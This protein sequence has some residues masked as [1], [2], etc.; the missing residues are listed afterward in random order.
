MQ[1]GMMAAVYHMDT[2]CTNNGV[3][4]KANHVIIVDP[5]LPQI[6]EATPYMPA[7]Y[8]IKRDWAYWYLCP[9]PTGKNYMFGGNFAYDCDSRSMAVLGNH[10]IHIFDRQ[11]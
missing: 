6:F 11:E 9:D 5:L 7:L 8:I 4:A 2:D 10:P 3:S 1:K